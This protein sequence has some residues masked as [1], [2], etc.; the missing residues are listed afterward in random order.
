VPESVLN[1][2]RLSFRLVCMIWEFGSVLGSVSPFCW[3][4]SEY[5]YLAG[6]RAKHGRFFF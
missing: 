5:L 4:V 6:N 3:C 2:V 1:E